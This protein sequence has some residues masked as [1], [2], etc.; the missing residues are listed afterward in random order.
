MASLLLPLISA[1]HLHRNNSISNTGSYFFN[2]QKLKHAH[3]NKLSCRAVKESTKGDE[4]NVER[5]KFD[6]RD[7]LLGLGGLYG[8]A[9]VSQSAV[10]AEPV[11]AVNCGNADSLPKCT[12]IKDGNC[13]PPVPPEIKIVDF[14]FP[15]SPSSPG[16][17]R[18]RPAAHLADDVYVAKY[19]KAMEIMRSLPEDHPHSF[20]T[21]SCHSLCL[22]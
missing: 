6:R 21:A 8:T 12:N 9:A 20:C 11:D 14:T 17:L 4:E 13:C 7:I 10:L 1:T 19:N 15:T 16:S 2:H 18:I 5:G 3:K 22:L